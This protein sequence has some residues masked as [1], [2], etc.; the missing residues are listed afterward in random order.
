MTSAKR[1][2]GLAVLAILA[3]GATAGASSDARLAAAVKSGDRALV[4]SLLKQSERTEVNTR[5][6]EGMTALN[7]AAY[8]DDLDLVKRL[9]AAGADVTTPNRGGGTPLHQACNFSDPALIDVLLKAGAD[10]NAVRDEGDTPLLIAAHVG[11]PEVAKLLLSHGA[12]VDTRDGWYGETPLMIAVAEDRA[13]FTKVLVDHGADVNTA[14]TTF[15]FNHRRLVDATTGIDPVNGGFTPLLFA[16]RQGAMEAA[17]V[18]IAAGADLNT[19]DPEYGYTPLMLSLYNWH[20]DF[21]KMLIQ[22]GAKVD[23]DPLN[24]IVGMRSVSVSKRPSTFSQDSLDMIS[25]LIAHGADPNAIF[26]KGTPPSPRGGDGG[27]GG[28]GGRGGGGT[29]FMT[30]ARAIDL[31]AMRLLIEKGVKVT[32]VARDGTT[33]IMALINGGAAPG[34]TGG[35]DAT[36]VPD[37]IKG[38]QLCLDNGVDINAVTGGAGGGGYLGGGTGGGNAALHYAAGLGADTLVQ[39][40][41]DHGAKLDIKNRKGRTPLQWAQGFR[42]GGFQNIDEVGET[43]YPSTI[44]LLTKLMNESGKTNAQNTGPAN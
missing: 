14:S 16:A 24:I 23:Q 3:L 11:N 25:L 13:E 21:A 44:A 42:P 41:V 20:T 35:I 40:L 36:R 29:P 4:Q 37:I 6:A 9:I 18:L 39:Y 17:Q 15:K 28:G 1:I 27:G 34:E 31:P 12:K 43:P 5:D 2:C 38:I 32:A 10:A 8:Q 33:P 22:N 7:W 30:A 19:G 26:R